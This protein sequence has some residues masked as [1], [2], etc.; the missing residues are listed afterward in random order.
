MQVPWR[1]TE[2]PQ[3]L[4]DLLRRYKL[5]NLRIK[6]GVGAPCM[7]ARGWDPAA[8]GRTPRACGVMT[9]DT[10][11]DPVHPERRGGNPRI[12]GKLPETQWMGKDHRG[13]VRE[14]VCHPGTGRQLEPTGRP[15]PFPGSGTVPDFSSSGCF[16]AD[17]Y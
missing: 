10:G 6:M 5:V 9:R 14:A 8:P 2:V 17:P 11:R 16:P 13:L 15:L 1:F 12:R 3:N 4:E 7:C